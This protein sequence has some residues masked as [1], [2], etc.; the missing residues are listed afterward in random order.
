MPPILTKSACLPIVKTTLYRVEEIDPRW[1][2]LNPNLR[3]MV[4]DIKKG[5]PFAFARTRE[6]AENHI[7]YA[8]GFYPRCKHERDYTGV[9]GSKYGPR[10]RCR[11]CGGKWLLKRIVLQSIRPP[12]DGQGFKRARRRIKKNLREVKPRPNTK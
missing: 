6:R 2:G 12:K 10:Y 8:T 7:K 1:K 9:R 3:Y 11:V 5:V 4:V